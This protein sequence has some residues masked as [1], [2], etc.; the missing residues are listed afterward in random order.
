MTTR[1]SGHGLVAVVLGGALA[2]AAVT[3][4]AAAADEVDNTDVN[5]SVDIEDG[6]VGVLALS[7][8]AD[9]VALIEEG[10]EL[11]VRQFVGILPTVTVIDTRTA[12]EVPDGATWSVLGSSSDLTGP[13]GVIGADHLGWTPRLLEGDEAGLIQAGQEVVTVLDDET[14]PGNDVGLVDQE[15]LFSTFASG[16]VIGGV[17]TVDAL[18]SLRTAAD[19]PAGSY[20][21]TLTLSLF[22]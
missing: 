13:A 5:I 4:P 15:L 9:S 12:Q 18:L 3:V 14:Q 16:E 10:S 2:V 11:G 1:T 20:A 22:E 21:S 6:E 8:A 17:Y 7:V 19:T